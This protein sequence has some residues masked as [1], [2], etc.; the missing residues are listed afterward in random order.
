M[1]FVPKLK[2]ITFSPHPAFPFGPCIVLM[3][4]GP[5]GVGKWPRAKWALTEQ[6]KGDITADVARVWAQK[7]DRRT[8]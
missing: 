3:H 8:T 6:R 5:A 7:T 2:P 4:L 1:C